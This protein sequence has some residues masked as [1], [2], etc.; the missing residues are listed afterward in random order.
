VP[1]VG[2]RPDAAGVLDA[3]KEPPPASHATVTG[4]P[5]PNYVVNYFQVSF[6]WK[7]GGTSRDQRTLI[8]VTSKDWTPGKQIIVIMD[9]R[10]RDWQDLMKPSVNGEWTSRPGYLLPGQLTGYERRAIEDLGVT[11]ANGVMLY[12]TD[13]LSGTVG[14]VAFAIICGCAALP[15][16]VGFV[17]TAFMKPRG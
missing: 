12:S 9:T 11:L 7:Y 14:L 8:P 15:L 6:G 17:V 3:L 13:R 2:S 4:V 16:L 10:G 1:P 5:R